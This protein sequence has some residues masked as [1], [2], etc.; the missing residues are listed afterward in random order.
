MIA[1]CTSDGVGRALAADGFALV[2][3]VFDADAVAAIRAELDKPM[4]RAS[5]LRRRGGA[6]AMRNVFDRAPVLRGLTL[7][8]QL[9]D[10]VHAAMGEAATLTRAIL[11][12]KTPNANWHVGWHQDTAVAVEQRV[13]TPGYGPWSVKAGV[14]HVQPPADVL[15]GMVTTRIHLDA[16]GESDGALMIIPGSH[17]AGKLASDAVTRC[18]QERD[19]VTVAADAGDVLLMRPLILHASRP[20]ERPARRRILHL[21]WAATALPGDLQ[22]HRA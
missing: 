9:L 12:D 18:V 13:D 22:W 3:A 15:A 20:A 16:C 17:A 7:A 1:S 5:V 14:T 10:V 2:R 11:F 8:P 21:E 19:A 4:D 6:Y